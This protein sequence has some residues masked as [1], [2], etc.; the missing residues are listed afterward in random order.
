MDRALVC[1]VREWN[2]DVQ[3]RFH[4][5][6]MMRGV[7]Y[8]FMAFANAR[9]HF[10][11]ICSALLFT[12]FGNFLLLLA[13]FHSFTPALPKALCPEGEFPHRRCASDFQGISHPWPS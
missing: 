9:C 4:A 6:P 2:V 10:F 12:F 11:G 1:V 5:A 3:K 13:L 7:Y 8:G